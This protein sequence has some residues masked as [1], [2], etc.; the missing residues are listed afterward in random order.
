MGIFCLS[1]LLS[2]LVIAILSSSVEPESCVVQKGVE[3]ECSTITYWE[4]LYLGSILSCTGNTAIV[5]DIPGSFVSSVVYKDKFAV[6]TSLI[7][8]IFFDNAPSLKFLPS[9]I[10]N[11]FPNMRALTISHCN[12]Q[13]V[14]QQDFEPFGSSLE[15]IMLTGNQLTSIEKDLF[16]HNTNLKFIRL[17]SN[18]IRYISPE[19]FNHLKN[20]ANLQ[21]VDFLKLKTDLCMDQYREDIL[22][23]AKESFPKYNWDVKK[24]NNI[25]VQTLSFLK[26][27]NAKIHQNENIQSCLKIKNKKL[28]DDIKMIAHELARL[29]AQ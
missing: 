13:I 8:A 12:L 3:I 18:P 16:D 9:G 21:Y 29:R 11:N 5:S 23:V 25:D 7:H 28:E 1:I 4:Y 15:N 17:D 19:F 26:P 2:T 22:A 14:T 20:L 6:P 24:C 10:K 27:L